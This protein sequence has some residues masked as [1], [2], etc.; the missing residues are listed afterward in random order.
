MFLRMHI[1]HF[2]QHFIY[3]DHWPTKLGLEM[4]GNQSAP[5]VHEDWRRKTRKAVA[6]LFFKMQPSSTEFYFS[7]SQTKRVLP[8]T[9]VRL[10]S[11]TTWT[12]VLYRAFHHWEKAYLYTSNIKI[13]LRVW[14]Y[15][16]AA[17]TWTN[18]KTFSFWNMNKVN[19][20]QLAMC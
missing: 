7:L 8:S 18:G 9:E 4:E 2:L 19:F 1:S 5:Y 15:Q 3:Q 10:T 16:S 11:V 13:V 6:K 20:F 12:G 14:D 17:D